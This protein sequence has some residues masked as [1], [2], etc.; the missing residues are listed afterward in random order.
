MC[1]LHN[2]WLISMHILPIVVRNSQ[3][4]L[5]TKK[6]WDGKCFPTHTFWALPEIL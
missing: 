1:N 4:K 3:R 6:V 2:D 5:M